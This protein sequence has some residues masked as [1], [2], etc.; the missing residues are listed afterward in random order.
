MK[1][2]GITFLLFVLAAAGASPAAA[3]DSSFYLGALSGK[4]TAKTGCSGT[5]FACN[6]A[7]P[8]WGVFTGFM[9]NRNWGAE[10]GY[11]NLGKIS[12]H[13]DNTGTLTANVKTRVGEVVGIGALPIERVSLYAKIGAYRAKSDLTSTYLTEGS[14]KNNGLTYGVGA[15]YDVFRHLALR[16]EWQR[17]NNVG[18]DAVGFRTDIETFSGG[19][20][21]TF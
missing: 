9:W 6:N 8:I 18:G 14:S 17:Y 3:E 4:G 10:A 13:A 16:V 21:L 19:A 2:I 1:T 12:D 7:D 20:L 15:R 11:R 5:A